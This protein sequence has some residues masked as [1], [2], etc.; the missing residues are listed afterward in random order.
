MRHS[1]CDKEEILQLPSPLSRFSP[2]ELALD[3]LGSVVHI[4]LSPLSINKM[5][6]VERLTV[7]R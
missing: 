7:D 6:S 4:Q 5:L 2:F 3:P 1:L